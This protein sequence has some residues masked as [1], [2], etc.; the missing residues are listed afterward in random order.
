MR[1]PAFLRR[2]YAVLARVSPGCPPLIGRFPSV[3]HPSASR[4][5]VLLHLLPIDLHVLGT[6]PAFN[7][8]QDQTLHLNAFKTL[9]DGER[10]NTHYWL[11]VTHRRIPLVSTDASPHTNYLFRLLKSVLRVHRRPC[12]FRCRQ[13]E[14][15]IRLFRSVNTAKGV[16]VPVPGGVSR[17]SNRRS[18]P[19]GRAVY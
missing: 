16:F 13:T 4:Q 2:A 5:H 3:T 11:L 8:S 1:S 9:S 19:R 7:L 15:Y 12:N 6:P 17:R 10:S 18:P 14:K